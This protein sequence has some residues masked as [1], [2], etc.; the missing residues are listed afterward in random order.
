MKKAKDLRRMAGMITSM[1]IVALSFFPIVCAEGG[2]LNIVQLVTHERFEFTVVSGVLLAAYLFTPVMSLVN[3]ST[4][5]RKKEGI[6]KMILSVYISIF[7]LLSVIGIG[8]Y[9]E[10]IE[11]FEM[12][13]PGLTI[14]VIIRFFFGFFDGINRMSGEELFE[15]ILKEKS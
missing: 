7:G 11:V 1:S 2:N 15:R 3:Y 4:Y 12:K 10:A 9:C 13:M 8:G 6:G 5:L 14:W